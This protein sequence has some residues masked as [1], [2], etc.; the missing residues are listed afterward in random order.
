MIAEVTGEV[1]RTKRRLPATRL[2]GM[3]AKLEQPDT[4]GNLRPFC[5]A[6]VF[7]LV[8]QARKRPGVRG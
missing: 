5:Q 7:W 2:L 3:A 1:L 8:R 6:G 4:D